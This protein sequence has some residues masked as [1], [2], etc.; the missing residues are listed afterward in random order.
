MFQN[1]P[2]LQTC[3]LSY[4]DVST[5]TDLTNLFAND[6]QLQTVSLFG[7]Q[8]PANVTVTNTFPTNVQQVIVQG[9]NENT[10]TTVQNA[11]G[12]DKYQ[13]VNG[14]FIPK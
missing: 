9:C 6:T 10:V 11:L 12:E 3:D 4:W 5:V 14:V 13:L 2:K 7:W 8:L 1:L